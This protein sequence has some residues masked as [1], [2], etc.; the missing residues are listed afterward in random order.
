MSEPLLKAIIQLFAIVAKEDDVTQQ[1]REQIKA[2]LA[3]NLNK[4]AV[5]RYLNQFDE[6][7]DSIVIGQAVDIKEEQQR[8]EKFCG[9]IKKELTQTQK[10]VI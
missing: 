6:Y 2:F 5:D 7:S 10:V 4:N 1:E 8:I 3:E 9:R